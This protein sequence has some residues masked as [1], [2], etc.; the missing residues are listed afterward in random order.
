MSQLPTPDAEIVARVA[1]LLARADS[2]LFIT[3]AGLSADSGLPTYRGIG[4]LYRNGLTE[5]GVP[6]EVALSGR[7]FYSRPEVSWRSIRQVADACLGA[8]PNR[9]HE[10]IA[11]L[12]R[13]L[14]RVWILTQNVDGFHQA[15]GSENVIAI[16]GDVGRLRCTRCSYAE[17]VD[18]FGDLAALPLCP[19]CEAVIRPDVVLFGE[20][21]PAAALRTL[22]RELARGFDL[23]F[24]VGT[25]SLFPYIAQPMLDARRQGVPTVEINP[26]Q[27]G[28]ST[29]ADYRLRSGA[30]AAL[31]AL[32]TALDAATARG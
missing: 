4:G 25:S 32:W 2:A 17:G 6:V 10:V 12:E 18:G 20:M 13:R 11:D 5:D 26:E 7:M 27:T 23:V 15:A 8:G 21:L 24:S 31:D 16:H 3:G 30:A 22:Q 1:A 28:V 9:G 14:D 29:F 19:R